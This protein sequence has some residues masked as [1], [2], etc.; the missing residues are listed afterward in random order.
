MR[1]INVP[2]NPKK[3]RMGK[4]RCPECGCIFEYDYED[5][6]AEDRPCSDPYVECPQKGCGYRVNQMGNRA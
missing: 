1:T 2:G 4:L 3:K 5:V 6:K